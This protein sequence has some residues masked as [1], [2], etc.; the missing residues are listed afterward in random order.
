MTES[1]ECSM[2]TIPDIDTIHNKNNLKYEYI[3]HLYQQEIVFQHL[4][5]K[6]QTHEK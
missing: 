5:Y 4:I 3:H 1:V 2:T 6:M